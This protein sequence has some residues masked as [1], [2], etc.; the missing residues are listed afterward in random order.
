M[1]RTLD[2]AKALAAQ[3]KSHQ[4]RNPVS[5]L[6]ASGHSLRSSEPRQEPVV[7]GCGSSCRGAKQRRAHTLFF[8]CPAMPVVA[9]ADGRIGLRRPHLILCLRRNIPLQEAHTTADLRE[10]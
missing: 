3:S 6:S 4:H 9:T 7:A 5:S 8:A 10:S 1:S 2:P